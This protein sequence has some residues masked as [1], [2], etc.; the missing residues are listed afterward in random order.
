MKCPNCGYNSFDYLETCK[1][2]G[3][4]LEVNPR[5]RV[6]YGLAP[7]EERKEDLNIKE[8]KTTEEET[9]EH[10]VYTP[11]VLI[12]TPQE[13]IEFKIREDETGRSELPLTS[14]YSLPQDTRAFTK[15]EELP[16]FNLAG[17]GLRAGAFVLDL[18]ILL[19]VTAL[20]L[21]FG[22][23]L[24][25]I[26]FDIRE[27]NLL[28]L[29]VPLFF[30]LFSLST[31]YFLFLQG[32]S[33]KTIGKMIFGIRVIRKDGES[34]GFWDALIRWLGYFISMLFIFIGFIW[35]LFDPKRQA[36]HDKFAETYVVKE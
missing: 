7:K 1:K 17:I 24:G 32:F 5:Y 12:P 31:T 19:G 36:W 23:Y 21:W 11:P 29:I 25:D 10:F 22:L 9:K 8:S 6:I 20:T 3:G 2:C 14:Q 30:I 33:G 18:I 15:D 34:I 26:A 16:Q 13:S 4:A 27:S 35:A 28:N